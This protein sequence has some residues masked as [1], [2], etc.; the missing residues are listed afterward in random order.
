[1][2]SAICSKVRLVLSTSQTAVTFG[3][4]GRSMTCS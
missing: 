4:S 2:K 1:V 3:I